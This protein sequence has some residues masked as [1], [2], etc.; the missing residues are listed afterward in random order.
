MWKLGWGSEG[1]AYFRGCGEVEGFQDNTEIFQ[2]LPVVFHSLV[3]DRKD[4]IKIRKA[5]LPKCTACS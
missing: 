1:E 3:Q 5:E 4:K 2:K